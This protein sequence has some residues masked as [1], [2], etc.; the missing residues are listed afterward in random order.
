MLSAIVPAAGRGRRMGS[1][2]NKQFLNLKGVPILARTLQTLDEFH[3]IDEIFVVCVEDEINFCEENIILPYGFK[4][5]KGIVPGGARRQDSVANALATIDNAEYILVHD[6][7]RP[8]LTQDLLT[9]VI[10]G[11][12][13]HGAAG[14]AVPVK[15]T[16][17]LVDGEGFISHTPDRSQLWAMQT[18]QVFRAQILKQAY[19]K[20]A[21]DGFHGTD[22]SSLVERLGYRIKII[23]GTYNNIKVTTPEDLIIGE[24]I[25][26]NIE[27]RCELEDGGN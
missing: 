10:Q 12:Q 21:K 27:K 5:V 3:L 22:D 23:D 13:L 25:L 9:R 24:R 16:I 7:A 19:D 1:H 11:A 15:D 2:I 20:A 18:P 17:K 8:F 6:G 14:L 26:E 4:K